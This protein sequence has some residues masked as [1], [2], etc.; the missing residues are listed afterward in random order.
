METLDVHLNMGS[1]DSSRTAATVTLTDKH[2][3][4]V[5][6]CWLSV[7][8]KPNGRAEARLDVLGKDAST[9][10]HKTAWLP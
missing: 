2:T 5:A 6:R 9:D 4:R 3:G 7:R 10:S 8:I 1:D